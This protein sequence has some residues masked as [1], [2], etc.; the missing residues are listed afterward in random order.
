MTA[1]RQKQQPT[2]A[3]LT[4]PQILTVLAVGVV[5]TLLTWLVSPDLG[6]FFL[7]GTVLFG[8]AMAVLTPLAYRHARKHGE[9]PPK[10]S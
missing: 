8:L 9:W 2:P 4:T 5:V 3:L 10:G 1:E 7:V 6:L